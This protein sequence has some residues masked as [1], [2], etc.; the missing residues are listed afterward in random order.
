[1]S[2]FDWNESKN[3]KLKLERAI[4]F[5]DAVVAISDGRLHDVLEHSNPAKYPHQRFYIVETEDYIYVVPF[6]KEGEKIF[7]K[8]IYPS[9]KLTKQ[10]LKGDK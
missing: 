7:L 8:T 6:I 10:Y 3:D 1:V 2:Y 9:R 4:C 5:E